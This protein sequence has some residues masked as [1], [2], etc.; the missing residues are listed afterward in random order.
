MR[1]AIC[2]TEGC[3]FDFNR[4]SLDKYIL[5]PKCNKWSE[6]DMDQINFSWLIP[7]ER[8]DHVSKL[9]TANN[10]LL[11]R[12]REAENLFIEFAEGLFGITKDGKTL[13]C[14][15][16]DAPYIE[17]ELLKKVYKFWHKLKGIPK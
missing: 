16:G 12:T 13:D 9:L 8:K 14:H 15:R 4:Q 6:M 10:Q 7:N 2:K 3:G 5:C 11:E 17:K 1:N